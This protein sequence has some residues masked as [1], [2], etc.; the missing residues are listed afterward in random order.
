MA[1]SSKKTTA[2]IVGG[3]VVAALLWLYFRDHSSINQEAQT[4]SDVNGIPVADSSLSSQV[5][6]QYGFAPTSPMDISL[7]YNFGS[8]GDPGS[9]PSLIAPIPYTPP[10]MQ[11]PKSSCDG[12]GGCD[13]YNGNGFTTAQ[14][15]VNNFRPTG[16]NNPAVVDKPHIVISAAPQLFYY[17]TFGNLRLG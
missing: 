16:N 4:P 12:C 6:S 3:L 2:W 1:E 10:T 17:D 8:T 9:P 5:P 11:P 15:L 7:D 13:R 14:D